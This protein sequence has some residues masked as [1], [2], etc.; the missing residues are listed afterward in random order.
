MRRVSIIVPAYN[1][2]P[3]LVGVV[4]EIAAAAYA[5]LDD[6]EILIVDDGS[7]DQ[8]GT[9]ADDLA[10]EFPRVRAFHQPRNQG[11]AAAYARALT[12]ARLD[13]VTFLPADGEVAPFSIRAIFAAIG[14]ADLVVPYH[15][16]PEARQPH[17]RLLTWASTALVNLLFGLHLR[18]FQGPVVY[19]TDLARRLPKT[20]GGFYFLT[21]M[22]LHALAEGHTYTQVGLM[23]QGRRHGFSH[24]VSLGKILRALWTILTVWWVIHR[25]GGSPRV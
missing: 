17:R 10:R 18:Y 16:N 11:I 9:L 4:Q 22:L 3:T 24:A 7:T 19:P 8:T 12:V 1:E 6:H 13:F 23:H 14:T 15:A 5:L 2:A 20:A 21:Q 25:T